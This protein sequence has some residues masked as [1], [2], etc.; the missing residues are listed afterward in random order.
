MNRNTSYN[1][2]IFAL[3]KGVSGVG[4]I[5]GA[6]LSESVV[7]VPKSSEIGFFLGKFNDRTTE[8]KKVSFLSRQNTLIAQNSDNSEIDR[9]WQESQQLFWQGTPESLRAALEKQEAVR[10]LY[11]AA[12][13]K[14]IEATVLLNMSTTSELLRE[15]HQVLNYRNQALLL[16]QAVGERG[17]EANTLSMIG[18]AYDDLGE[19]QKALDYY[20]QALLLFQAVGLHEGEA[21]TLS[22]IG[23]RYDEL[24]EPQKALDY[25]NQALSIYQALGDR[26]LGDRWEEAYLLTRIS[27]VYGLLQEKQRALD[28][29]NQAISLYQALGKQEGEAGILNRI[30]D[31]FSSLGKLRQALDY[32]NRALSVYRL[33][34]DKEREAYAL[35]KISPVHYDLHFL[36][37]ERRQARQQA[38]DYYNQA[39]SLLRAVGDKER[40]ANAL[41]EMGNFLHYRLREKQ[42]TLDYYTQALSLY[43][44]LGDKEREAHT[45]YT[46][47]GVYYDFRE[48]QRALDYYNQVLSLYRAAGDKQKEAETLNM[49]GHASRALREMQQALNS[50]S[51]A[52]SLSRIVIDKNREYTALY[53]IGGVYNSLGEWQQALNYYNQALSLSRAER[54]KK[55][56]AY[57]FTLIG[58]MYRFLG[59]WQQAL[60]YYSQALSLYRVLGDK[61]RE[62][63]T[64]TLIGHV[65]YA[66]REAQQALNSYHQALSL[67]RLL[68]S[69][70][71][72]S[73]A[74]N[75][76]TILNFIGN[77]YYSL[78]EKQQALNY[79]NQVLSLLR[80]RGNKAWESGTLNTI[81]HVYSS[82]GETQRA[83][84]YYNQAL[85]LARSTNYKGEE[86]EALYSSA[87]LKR[88]QG[89]L[90]EA[91]TNIEAA[92]TI[93][94]ELRTKSNSQEERQS[95][96]ARYQDYYHFYIDLLMQLHQQNPNQG[97]DGQAL[98]ISEHTRARSLLELLTEATANIRTGADPKLLEQEHNLQQQLNAL[99][100][101][102]YQLQSG[103]YSQQELDKIRKEI[104]TVLVELNTIEAQ[105]RRNSPRYANLK[106]PQPLTL[107]EIQQQVLDDNTL[108]LQYSLG[109]ERSYLWA[110][111][112]N[113]ITSYV[114]PKQS[115][116]EAA[117]ETLRQ[118]ITKN[119]SSTLDAGLPLSQMLLAPVAHLLGNKRLLI[120][121][122]GVLQYVPFAAL[123][124]P[125]SPTTPLLVQ[126]EI[127][128]L[129]SAST[130]AIQR[131]QLQNRR[132][133]S[134]T[135]AVIAD[136][137]FSLTDARIA[138]NSPTATNNSSLSTLSLTR[139]A[140]NLGLGADGGGKL[141]DRLQYTR[142][143]ADKI[144]ALAPQTQR[145]QALDFEASRQT[146]T[147]PNLS[148]Y[149]IIH[150][151]THGLLD[152]INPELSGIVLSL[153]D[154]NGKPQ[155]G[156][157]RL[158]DI[159]NLELPAELVVLSACET[160]LGENIRGEGL[161]GLTRGFMYAGARRVVVSLW[162]VNDAATSEL[163]A[164]FYQKILQGGQNPIQALREAQLEMWNSPDRRSPY[165]W[166]AFTIQGD[167]R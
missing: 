155:D 145:L 120:V 115:E 46:I 128:T 43:R 2:L 82:L 95:F 57:I 54:N 165:Y 41:M 152:P 110:V 40:E 121:G 106:Y 79:Y 151:A 49:I 14:K 21:R 34:G 28:Y 35:I 150:F 75:E 74:G 50:Y 99:D 17:A 19:P 118:S 51:Q 163:M 143:E 90:T 129:P 13:D 80:A 157:L 15:W 167:W 59:E 116:I 16:F 22:M 96:F 58:D 73:Y 86:V 81:G 123:P 69:V 122:D 39:L 76:D 25:Y 119:S 37:P 67:L 87:R 1:K 137:V 100:T 48:Y 133:V 97:Y 126:N 134:K 27:L 66:L 5:L 132:P 101:R 114:L 108:L 38:L 36:L 6:L 70:D 104:D 24:G 20:N 139:A 98:H 63:S 102:R 159:F 149:Q 140:R 164:N 9:L 3:L 148:Q 30:G 138:N 162:S 45:L 18:D 10:Q 85:S 60:D 105:I 42:Q 93:I 161:V 68:R 124:I 47:G 125:N 135:V 88:N 64:L 55:S 61:E 89:N 147:N 107:Q 160:G 113:S 32:Y 4:I 144:L 156:F 142:T 62:A 109:E 130:V 31:N 65:Y 146:A 136:P 158:H 112:K 12:G 8:V 83:L 154:Q 77:V 91:L 52:L 94:E 111:T 33:V 92:I 56:E 127:V 53:S 103:Q 71:D 7:A 44:V 117:A 131:R 153:F 29:Y 84:D 72:Q 23:E 26:R 166:A 141:F 78:G 11:R